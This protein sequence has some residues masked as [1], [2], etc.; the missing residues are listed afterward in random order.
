ML[1]YLLKI[2]VFHKGLL[3]IEFCEIYALFNVFEQNFGRNLLFTLN[4]QR[5]YNYFDF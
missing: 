5:K 4:D 2:R 3:K 1:D